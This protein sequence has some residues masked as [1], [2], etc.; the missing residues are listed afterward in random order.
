M[1]KC[2]AHGATCRYC[3]RVNHYGVQC[4][5]GAATC[6]ACGRTS[7]GADKCP[8]SGATC[9]TYGKANHYAKMCRN[10]PAHYMVDESVIHTVGSDCKTITMGM[11]MCHF[12]WTLAR[13][14]TFYHYDNYV[15]ATDD[16][17][18]DNL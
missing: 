10:K 17:Q 18:C 5:A 9:P 6:P 15:R 14:W 2:P 7:H 4:P 16:Y 1:G 3:G 13:L 12:I 8:A 11:Q